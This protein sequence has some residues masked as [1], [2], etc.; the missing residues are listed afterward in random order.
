MEILTNPRYREMLEIDL[1]PPGPVLVW[2]YRADLFV[3]E[4]LFSAAADRGELRVLCDYG[5]KGLLEVFKIAHPLTQ[6]RHWSSNAML[7]TKAIAF[8]ARDIV[9]LGSHNWT[10]YALRHAINLSIRVQNADVA[11]RVEMNFE[12]LW[13]KAV[14]ADN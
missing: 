3:F 14:Q 13:V 2:V 12:L 8:P 11:R 6:L 9:Y 10:T 5:A 1:I 7:H 4:P